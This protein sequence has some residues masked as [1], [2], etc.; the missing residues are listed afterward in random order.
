M[1]P[2]GHCRG[3]NAPVREA[4]VSPELQ[5][6]AR[7]LMLLGAGLLAAGAVLFLVAHWQPGWS[8]PLNFHFQKGRFHFYFPLGLCILFSLLLTLILWI[9][10]K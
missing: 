5:P 4:H 6:L 10:R 7:L 1:I 3:K 2:C 8:I 9:F